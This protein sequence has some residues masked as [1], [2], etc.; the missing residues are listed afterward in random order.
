[1][2]E[3]IRSTAGGTDSEDSDIDLCIVIEDPT[4]RLRDISRKIRR[5]LYPILHKPID[6]LVYDKKTFEDRASLPVTMEG[7]ILEQGKAL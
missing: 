6:I 5:E 4:E 2:G 7:E 1:M 3:H